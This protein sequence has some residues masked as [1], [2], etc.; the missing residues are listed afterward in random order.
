MG[1]SDA[2]LMTL[3]HE[4]RSRTAMAQLVHFHV[5]EPAD[6]IRSEYQ[7]YW[8]DLCLTPRP[9]NARL[10]YRDRW[11]A[12]H[13]EQIGK[14]F[15]LPPSEKIQFRNEGGP[16]QTSMVCRLHPEAIREWFD[17][18][19]DWTNQRLT[20]ALDIPES[21]IR[22]LMLRLSEELRHPGFASEALAELITAQLAIELS[23]YCTKVKVHADGGLANWRLKRIDER[24]R[25]LGPSPSLSE[26]AQL[27][28]LSV[29]QMTRSFRISRHRSIGDHVANSRVEHAK[30]MLDG[31]Q[32]VKAIAYTLGFASPSSFSYAFRS[33][34]GATPK[35][36]RKEKGVFE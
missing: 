31:D 15:L 22:N 26:L 33:A 27:C 11:N 8:L 32:S 13:F 10:C 36:Y 21:N 34:V 14:L 17:G 25:E 16:S 24:L 20:A 29:R 9:A 28:G 12:G 7:D 19:L 4:I 5:H 2:A 23:R 30:R 6:T 18:E 1:R 35:E 3:D